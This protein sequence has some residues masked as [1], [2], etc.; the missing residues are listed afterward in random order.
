V[1]KSKY[2]V[3]LILVTTLMAT[4]IPFSAMVYAQNQDEKFKKIAEQAKEKVDELGALTGEALDITWPTEFPDDIKTAYND[5]E[6]DL[7]AGDY[8]EAMKAY[9]EVFKMLNIYAEARGAVFESGVGGEA[10]GL[11]V[12]IDRAKERIAR[13]RDVIAS[14]LADNPDADVSAV[15][16][17]LDEAEGLLGEAEGLIPSDIPTAASKIE[18][19]NEKI[20]E[21]FAALKE[22]ASWLNSWRVESFLMGIRKSV[23]RTRELLERAEKQ[24]LDVS[25]LMDKLQDVEALIDKA[26]NLRKAGDIKGAIE[27]LKDIREILRDIHQELAKLRKG[28]HGGG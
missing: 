2:L 28:G 25:A 22:V 12:A 8:K 20:S 11:F 5:A 17:L 26:G 15:E 23:E 13:I 14:I 7:A 18:E 24:E 6:N 21:A 16:D 9:R 10:Q 27:T 3:G 19:A 1:L 4:L